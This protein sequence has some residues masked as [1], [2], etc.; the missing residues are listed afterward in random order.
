MCRTK[1]ALGQPNLRFPLG[2]NP[3][4]SNKANHRVAT[5]V[6]TKFNQSF[7]FWFA[8][9]PEVEVDSAPSTAPVISNTESNRWMNRFEFPDY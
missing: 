4:N 9:K 2:L 8:D 3:E 7:K 6:E 1:K 5:E